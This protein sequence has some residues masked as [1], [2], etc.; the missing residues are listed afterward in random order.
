VTAS[1]TIAAFAPAGNNNA[2]A[3]TTTSARTALTGASSGA[4]TLVQ[5][6]GAN[7]VFVAF[8]D[9]T[10]VATTGSTRV[11]AGGLVAFNIGTAT[12]I[13]YIT[14]SST[15]T[16]S[17]STGTGLPALAVAGAGGSGGSVTQGTTPW[18]D[19]ISQFGGSN[20]VTGTGLSGLGIPRVTVSSDSSMTANPGTTTSAGTAWSSGTAGGTT[21]A[22]MSSGGWA[23]LLV[24]L[25]QTSTISA[26][27]VTFQ[28]SYDGANW[29]AI[30]NAQILNPNTMALANAPGGVYT[31]VASTNQPFLILTQGYQQVRLNLSTPITGSGTVTPQ[32]AL[33]PYNPTVAALLNPT[34]ISQTTDGT[35]NAVSAHGAVNVTMNDCSGTIGTGGTA[36]NAIS[37]QTTL[38]GFTI[39]N[40][41]SSAGSGE[42]LWISFTGTATASTNGSYPLIPPASTTQGGGSFTTPLG[43]GTSHAVSIVGATTGHKFSCTWW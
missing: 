21:Q 25:N 28:G 10:V 34:A 24:Q 8:G 39:A 31:L 20:V 19:N 26:G 14:A 33:L 11:P 18:V 42:N 2:I 9:G 12:N 29:T 1:A 37:A 22:L 27:A 43:M 3:V 40:V 38:H 13:A 6:S 15:S 4:T 30:P 41:D 23:A 36:Q 16:I 32:I 7:D 17:V 35:T 5:N